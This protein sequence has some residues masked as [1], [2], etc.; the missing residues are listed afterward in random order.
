MKFVVLFWPPWVWKSS[1]INFLKNKWKFAIDVE[2]F[3]NTRRVRRRNL[4]FLLNFFVSNKTLF[5]D[6]V[7]VGGWDSSLKNFK[8]YDIIS[9]LLLPD[10]DVWQKRMTYRNDLQ[11]DKKW[12]NEYKYYIGFL[13]WIINKF[14]FKFFFN[15]NK[16]LYKKYKNNSYL[17]DYVIKNN[18]SL[19]DII[20]IINN[21]LRN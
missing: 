6:V 2:W 4:K 3:W 20:V 16:I 17:F 1:I 13:K 9:I 18:W 21:I 12:Q 7:Y 19:E 15:K 11:K 14:K 5:P 8:W 10:F